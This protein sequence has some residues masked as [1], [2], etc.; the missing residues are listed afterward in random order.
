[1]NR[2][3]TWTVT[4][5]VL[6]VGIGTAAPA[7]AAPGTGAGASNA[8]HT[9]EITLLAT[10]DLHGRVQDWDY[11]RNAPYSESSGNA[12]GLAR[13]GSVVDS[14]RA[15]KGAE[16]VVVVD[17][18]DALQGTPLTYYYASQEPVTE[19]GVEHP[20]AAAYDAIGYDAQV[21]GNHEYNYGLDLLDAYIDDVDHPVLGANVMDVATGRPYHQPYTLK[22]IE[23]PGQKPITVGILGLTTPGSAIWD[24]GN[25]EGKVEFGDMVATAKQWV[26]VVDAV[27]DV[28]V[29]LSHAGVGGTS[30][31]AD[32]NVPTENPTDTIAAQVPGID[33]MVV[34]HTH[35]N[36]PS[37][38][39]VNEQTGKK[40]LLTQPYRWGASVSQVD[41]DLT[42]V[43]GQWSVAG[44]AATPLY[45]KNYPEDA[46]VLAATADAHKKTVGYVNQFVAD[47]TEELRAE[48]S[49]FEDT[50][51]LDYIQQVQTETVDAALEGTDRADLPVL[52][53]AA[54]FSRE[55]VFPKGPVT[56]RDIAGLYIYDNT[57]EAV[58]LS[59]A[60]VRAYLEESARYF[61]Q[62]TT[63]GPITSADLTTTKPDYNY[64]TLSGVDYELDISKP[65]GQRVTRLEVGGVPVA[66]DDRFV[67]AVNN[68]RRSGGGGFPGISTAPVVYNQQ[69][70]I[71]QLLI[72][73]AQEKTVIDPA[74]FYDPNWQLIANGQPVTD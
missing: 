16:N 66:A 67:V 59:G 21:V 39:V 49:W 23:V 15:Q 60:Q 58:E 47:S 17:N 22:R 42:K 2:R 29:V 3:T 50:P 11:F 10:T 40:V 54:P 74:D 32:P 24:K 72:E 28:V 6:A 48:T 69:Q 44:T 18:G 12:T 71:R 35:R 55:A 43:R 14:V 56:I 25:V 61:G 38:I 34:G 51:I 8:A 65:V 63:A 57:L 19:T 62:V 31:Y 46:D 73:W 9:A 30:S 64:D 5:A 68:Y 33:V 7:A 20:M 53:L 26:P 4:A 70:E 36:A 27:S 52:S 13:V 1:M 37:Q 45:T 41:I